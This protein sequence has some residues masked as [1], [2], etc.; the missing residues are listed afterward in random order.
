MR[1]QQADCV[2]RL[3]LHIL[4]YSADR[5]IERIFFAFLSES[6]ADRPIFLNVIWEMSRTYIENVKQAAWGAVGRFLRAQ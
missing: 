4:Q 2:V 3:L 5:E 6:S 1:V